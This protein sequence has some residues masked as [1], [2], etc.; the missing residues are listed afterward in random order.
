MAICAIPAKTY[1]RLIR[2]QR[3]WSWQTALIYE[4]RRFRGEAKGFVVVRNRRF[5]P[6]GLVPAEDLREAL[7]GRKSLKSRPPAEEGDF[8]PT[9]HSAVGW[10]LVPGS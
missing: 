2:F 1:F 9:S 3:T 4:K 10:P 6:V 5:G 8:D 7:R